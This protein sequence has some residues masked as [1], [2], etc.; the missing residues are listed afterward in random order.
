M[1]GQAGYLLLGLWPLVA[2]AERARNHA[3]AGAAIAAAVLLGGLAILG[4]T[5]AIVPA[6]IVSALVIVAVL[7]GRRARLWTLIAVGAGVALAAPQLLDVFQ[8]ARGARP[9]PDTV[10]SGVASLLA[11]AAVTGMVFAIARWLA[12]TA[13]P[14][15]GARQLA[16]ASTVALVAVLVVGAVAS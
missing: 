6:V 14:R 15:V 11:I 10:R 1:N 2:V 16:T 9:D 12:R 4:Q 5:R 8:S 7:P 3:F 13:E